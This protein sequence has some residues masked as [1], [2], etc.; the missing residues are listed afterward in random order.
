MPQVFR[1]DK[2]DGVGELVITDDQGRQRREVVHGDQYPAQMAA[3]SAWARGE[4]PAPDAPTELI[5][6]ARLI[7]ACRRSLHDVVIVSL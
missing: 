3:F 7:E 4:G 5:D 6:Q 1:P 2:Q